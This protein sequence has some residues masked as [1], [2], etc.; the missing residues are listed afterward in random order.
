M[1]SATIFQQFVAVCFDLKL[2]M[3]CLTKLK[4]LFAF[5]FISRLIFVFYQV[6]PNR[7]R[8]KNR[9]IYL[10]SQPNFYIT[11]A[12]VRNYW[13]C[14][15]NISMINHTGQKVHSI[16]REKDWKWNTSLAHAE[17]SELAQTKIIYYS[18]FSLFQTPL[19]LSRP[20]SSPS[21]QTRLT[22]SSQIIRWSL[23]LVL[24]HLKIFTFTKNRCN[25][26]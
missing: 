26:L 17:K 14:K 23:S 15:H 25:P 10:S 20:F 1:F 3:L 2:S 7:N 12:E 18:Q 16:G 9:N 22:G 21:A 24:Q 11:L 13:W 19:F 6:S 4:V 5:C 8:K